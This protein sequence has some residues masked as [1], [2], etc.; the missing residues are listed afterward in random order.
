M[1]CWDD[2][3]TSSCGNNNR[4]P[5]SSPIGFGPPPRFP[6]TFSP[7]SLP[8]LGPGETRPPS[9]APTPS[10]TLP[11]TSKPTQQLPPPPKVFFDIFEPGDPSS[12]AFGD[13]QCSCSMD[14]WFRLVDSELM[15][16]RVQEVLV[17]LRGKGSPSGS[18]Q[19]HLE[20]CLNSGDSGSLNVDVD[21]RRQLRASY[22]LNSTVCQLSTAPSASLVSAPSSATMSTNPPTSK[23]RRT[24][25]PIEESMPAAS[26]VESIIPGQIS[27]QDAPISRVMYLNMLYPSVSC[28]LIANNANLIPV[29]C[30]RPYNAPYFFCPKTCG[31]C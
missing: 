24:L 28:D 26:P 30:A 21:L 18:S 25:P 17:E 20:Q 5:I 12:I 27:C 8:P 19:W 1:A 16:S 15:S 22:A 14:S 2:C 7:S 13:D 23:N 9:F 31:R 4:P 3:D 29:A 10:P 11:P 6:A